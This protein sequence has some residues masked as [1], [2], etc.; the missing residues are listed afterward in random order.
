MRSVGDAD[1][2]D[3]EVNAPDEVEHDQADGQCHR[4]H[5]QPRLD[6]DVRGLLGVILVPVQPQRQADPTLD[7][8]GG[9]EAVE[10]H[11]ARPG[12][13]GGHRHAQH[14]HGVDDLEKVRVDLA[15]NR[16]SLLGV[17][18]EKVSEH[19]VDTEQEREIVTAE[20]TSLLT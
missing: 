7:G 11:G 14:E 13:V 1:L 17:D 18:H 12:E 5:Y 3:E 20:L 6:V 16:E 4:D 10:H 19:E 15:S 9:P 2:W 8:V